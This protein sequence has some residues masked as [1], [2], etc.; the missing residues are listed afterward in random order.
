MKK[1]ILYLSLAALVFA[2]CA[3]SPKVGVND[4]AKRSLEAWVQVYHPDAIR[5]PLGAYVLDETPGT[6]TSASSPEDYP[7][8]RVDYTVRTLNGTVQGTSDETLSKQLGTYEKNA[9]KNPYYGPVVWVRGASGQTAGVEESLAA[10]NVGGRRKVMIPGWLLG[11]DASTGAPIL[12]SKAEYYEQKVSGSTPLIYEIALREVIPDIQ[13]W[14]IDSVGRYVAANYP[15]KSVKDSVKLG[16][17]YFQTGA[18]SSSETFK[19]DSTI[20]IN[21]I[22]RRLDGTVFDTSIADTAKYYGIYSASRTYGPCS[23]KW[24]GA[25]K[26]YTSITMTVSGSS[27]SSS[28]INGF[29]YG[30]DQ[31]HPHEKGTAI[32]ISNWGYG[33]KGS[34]PSIPAYSPLRFD[35]EIVDKP[36]S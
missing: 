19:N 21:Y 35:L 7:F 6:G 25:D 36:A 17:Y 11:L 30:L 23:I 10:M 14:Q 12:Y 34:S 18:P 32:F 28:V 20:Y 24:Y 9:S 22:G 15:G 5:T 27:S 13:Q 33:A 2:G 8:V 1:T 4:D 29:G 16:F 31:M 26:D 3:K